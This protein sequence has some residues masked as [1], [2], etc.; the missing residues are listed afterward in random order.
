MNKYSNL[1]IRMKKCKDKIRSEIDG[2]SFADRKLYNYSPLDLEEIE[3]QNEFKKQ[4]DQL[5]D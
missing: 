1:K 3:R 2:Q 4:E 5:R